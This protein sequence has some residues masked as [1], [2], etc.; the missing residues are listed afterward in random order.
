VETGSYEVGFIGVLTD[1]QLNYPGYNEHT[2]L[3]S[4]L[5]RME[6][7][8]K[9]RQHL[10]AKKELLEKIQKTRELLEIFTFRKN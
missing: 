5:N 9:Y 4:N 10:T 6:V 7:I 1:A 2:A 3:K 8:L